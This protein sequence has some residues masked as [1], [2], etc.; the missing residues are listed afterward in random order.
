MNEHLDPER[1]RLSPAERD[2][3][4]VLRPQVFED[5]TGQHKILANLRV[6]VQAARQRGEALDHVLL[7]GPPGLGKTTLSHILAQ[8]MGC[9]L[10]AT[11]GPVLERP[12][13]LAGFL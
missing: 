5:F 13:D 11:S 9:E 3:E 8:E 10:S 6:F 2:I 4:Q 12:A 1:E 7:H